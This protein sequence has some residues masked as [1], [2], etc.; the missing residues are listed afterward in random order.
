MGSSLLDV[1][2]DIINETLKKKP[3]SPRSFA[4]DVVEHLAIVTPNSGRVDAAESLS[5]NIILYRHLFNF[6]VIIL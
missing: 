1:S 5:S 3:M 6:A 2:V 4:K